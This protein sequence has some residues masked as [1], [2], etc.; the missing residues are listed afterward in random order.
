MVLI[1]NGS[2]SFSRMHQSGNTCFPKRLFPEYN[3]PDCLSVMVPTP[4]GCIPGPGLRGPST[5]P[6][7][8]RENNVWEIDVVGIDAIEK[9]AFVITNH[10]LKSGLFSSDVCQIT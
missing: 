4:E 9:H 8:I 7:S 3:Y 2:T 10:H 1:S 6:F 5:N